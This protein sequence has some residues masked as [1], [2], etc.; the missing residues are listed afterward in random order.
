MCCTF[1]AY[2]AAGLLARRAVEQVA[3]LRLVPL[4]MRTLHQKLTWLFDAGHLP[5]DA[6]RDARAVRDLG[7]AAAH[8][9]EGVTMDEA[10]SGVRASLAVAAGVLLPRP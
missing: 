2:R 4:E 10:C 3:V 8:G 5:P 6:V 9:S 1:G 7:N